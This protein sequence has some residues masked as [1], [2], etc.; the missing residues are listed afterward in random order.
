MATLDEY[1]NGFECIRFERDDL[2]I[3][4]VTLHRDGGSL[5]W[6]RDAH[7]EVSRMLGV[8]ASDPDNRVVIITGTGADFVKFDFD[9]FGPPVTG[10]SA[11]GHSAN[12]WDPIMTAEHNLMT[13]HLSIPVPVIAA[14]NGPCPVHADIALLSDIVLATKDTYFADMSHFWSNG[15]VPG[16]GIHVLWPALIGPNRARQ[17]LMAGSPIPADEALRLGLIGEIVTET[18]V[19]DRAY[20]HA[21]RIAGF[22][23]MNVRYTRDLLTRQLR[24]AMHEELDYGLTLQGLAAVA[25]AERS[26]EASA[27]LVG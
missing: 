22:P 26:R 19:L 16:D 21:R 9:A 4:Q 15:T 27:T 10:G 12:S 13:G 25:R 3:L 20:E 2:G 23:P 18:T 8:V 6:G 1:Q 14:V 24:K 17:F 7:L 11:H 5:L